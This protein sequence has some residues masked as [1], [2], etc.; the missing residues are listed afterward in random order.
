ML[1][2]PVTVTSKPVNQA[3]TVRPQVNPSVK[4]VKL[5]MNRDNPSKLNAEMLRGVRV[6]M[7][8]VTSDPSVAAQLES[9][10]A[11]L[12]NVFVVDN[13]L[14]LSDNPGNININLKAVSVDAVA[15]DQITKLIKAKADSL[16]LAVSIAKTP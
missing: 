1:I 2:K 10:I 9:Y 16:H 3:T 7:V 13:Q 5:S 11:G 6:T 8:G 4:T 15:V 14:I 12:E